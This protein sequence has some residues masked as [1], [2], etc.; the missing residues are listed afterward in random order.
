MSAVVIE[1]HH[2]FHTADLGV[3]TGLGQQILDSVA[4]L[5]ETLKMDMLQLEAKLGELK[6]STDKVFGEVSG[7]LGEL[8]TTVAALQ[9][10]L[11]QA[12]QTT[13][14]VDA[15]LGQMTDQL[16]ALDALIPDAPPA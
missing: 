3:P 4:S 11:A 13:P 7:K 9:D 15:L 16:N 6:A 5:K 8:N 12:E 1:V 10:A 14:A 2:Y